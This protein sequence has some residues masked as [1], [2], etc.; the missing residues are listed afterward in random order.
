[1]SEEVQKQETTETTPPVQENIELQPAVVEEAPIIKSE[2]NKENWKRFREE[3][4]KDRKARIEAEKIANQ[5]KAEAE[6]LKAAMEAL[7]AKPNPQ[8]QQEPQF[9]V[10]A[11]EEELIEKKVQAA[12][13]KERIRLKQEEKQREAHELPKKLEQTYRDFNK[14]C[15]TENLD[16]LEYHYPEVAKA[17]QYMPDGFDKWASVYQAVKRFVPQDSKQDAQRIEQNNL[18]PK[19]TAPVLTDTKPVGSPWI[20]T[21]ERKRANWERMMRERK[22]L[23]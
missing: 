13:E 7:I 8:Y 14:V 10:E 17:F 12:L 20:L 5:K 2:A 9:H 16:Y 4:E 19:T 1:M 6:A 21:E 22:S 11:S 23:S 15:S 3:R 18:K